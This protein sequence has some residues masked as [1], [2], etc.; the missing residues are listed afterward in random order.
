MVNIRVYTKLCVYQR[1]TETTHLYN[2]NTDRKKHSIGES[3]YEK[4]KKL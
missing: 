3:K 4:Q 1:V 2:N